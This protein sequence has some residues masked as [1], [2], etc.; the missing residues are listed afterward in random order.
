MY[1]ASVGKSLGASQAL[2]VKTAGASSISMRFS[3]F[4]NVLNSLRI[5][6]CNEYTFRIPAYSFKS[7][8][9]ASVVYYKVLWPEKNVKWKPK[10]L[11]DFIRQR[12]VQVLLHLTYQDFVSEISEREEDG[13][14]SIDRQGRQIQAV[15]HD[16]IL[17][18]AYGCTDT[19]EIRKCISEECRWG[20]RWWKIASNTGLGVL[21]LASD[22]LA[23]HIGRNTQV[24]MVDALAIYIRN[25]YPKLVA[26]FHSL[27]RIV[28][29]I[30]LAGSFSIHDGS[31]LKEI[32]GQI[33]EERLDPRFF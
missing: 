3:E 32:F 20:D 18:D 5:D 17:Q 15:A 10:S 12:I 24:H 2:S 21:L 30:M 14:L 9:E 4:I 28:Q 6:S 8:R 7:L 19:K 22:H 29:N 13:S 33:I 11:A 1:K 16:W 26:F 25:T 23:K 27:A 31:E